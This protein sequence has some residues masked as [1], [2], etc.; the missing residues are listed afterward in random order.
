MAISSE[1]VKIL[2]NT[3]QPKSFSLS[4]L[5][6]LGNS[7]LVLCIRASPACFADSSICF[8]LILTKAHEKCS[9]VEAQG[10]AFKLDEF[11]PKIKHKILVG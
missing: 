3:L 7:S 1:K 2:H 5:T 10:E 9:R 11:R 4:F 6:T 8:H